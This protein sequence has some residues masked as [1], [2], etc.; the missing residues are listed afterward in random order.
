MKSVDLFAGADGLLVMKRNI[1]FL[2][3]E[4]SKRFISGPNFPSGKSNSI[5]PL[6]GFSG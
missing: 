5:A 3:D 4:F 2:L 6:K 1:R